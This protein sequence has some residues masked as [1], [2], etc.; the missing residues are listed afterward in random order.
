MARCATGGAVAYPPVPL[1]TQ[2]R[3]PLD[4]ASGLCNPI[5]SNPVQYSVRRLRGPR[6]RTLLQ[7]MRCCALVGFVL[8]ENRHDTLVDFAFD[9]QPA[10]WHRPLLQALQL[11]ASLE[12]SHRRPARPFRR[13]PRVFACDGLPPQR[14]SARGSRA[15]QH[16]PHGRRLHCARHRSR[17]VFAL[18]RLG[19]LGGLHGAC[20]LSVRL[21]SLLLTSCA[22][23]ACAHSTPVRRSSLG[24]KTQ[25]QNPKS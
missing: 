15:L 5:Q 21:R 14:S 17:T 12:S 10:S 8:A 18:P 22:M 25:T 24:L 4:D 9:S 13:V 1:R 3:A 19:G 2:A 23:H 11:S 7:W 20:T 16:R 6:R